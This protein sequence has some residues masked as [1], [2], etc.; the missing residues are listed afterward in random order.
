M[1]EVESR[2]KY[3][4]IE[5]RILV[6]FS[7]PFKPITLLLDSNLFLLYL[8][9]DPLFENTKPVIKILP[10]IGEGVWVYFIWNSYFIWKLLKQN[11]IYHVFVSWYCKYFVDRIT[12]DSIFLLLE[13]NHFYNIN[14]C[15]LRKGFT[16]ISFDIKSHCACKEFN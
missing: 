16:Q 8:P 7:E 3:W 11:E 1:L 15:I 9:W 14:Y 2:V 12:W 4:K 10:T 13:W 5:K 6:T